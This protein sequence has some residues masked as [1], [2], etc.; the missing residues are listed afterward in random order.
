M[1]PWGFGKADC[2]YLS[3]SFRKP[4]YSYPAASENMINFRQF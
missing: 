1:A 4:I 3:C 2:D